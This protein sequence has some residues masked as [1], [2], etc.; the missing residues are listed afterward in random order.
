MTMGHFVPVDLSVQVQEWYWAHL[1]YYHKYSLSIPRSP[2]RSL[3]EFKKSRA[4]TGSQEHGTHERSMMLQ[5]CECAQRSWCET[6]R[7][8]RRK[9]YENIL[10]V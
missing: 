7:I 9:W 2:S 5:T 6:L 1:I 10:I 8:C 3:D 4:V